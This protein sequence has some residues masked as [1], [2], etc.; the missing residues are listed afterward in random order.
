MFDTEK[1]ARQA[2]QRADETEI[3]RRNAKR[4]TAAI[5]T[6]CAAGLGVFFLVFSTDIMS[7]AP[8]ADDNAEMYIDDQQVPLAPSPDRVQPGIRFGDSELTIIREGGEIQYGIIVVGDTE[9]YTF[10]MVDLTQEGDYTPQPIPDGIYRL[11]VGNIE[12]G[13]LT[14]TAGIPAITL[15]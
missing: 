11:M 13:T 12:I 15:W 8:Y 5:L 3:K 14:V 10:H 9:E 1:I 2:L 4:G 6:V 7:P